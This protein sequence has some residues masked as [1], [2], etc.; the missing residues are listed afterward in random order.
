VDPT[1]MLSDS[2][3]ELLANRG[4]S[5]ETAQAQCSVLT[6]GVAAPV[7]SRAATVGDGVVR[8]APEALDAHLDAFAALARRGEVGFFVPASGAASRMF[9]TLRQFLSGTHPQA[10]AEEARILALARSPVVARNLWQKGIS[11]TDAR[12]VARLLVSDAPDGYGWASRPKA[13][14]PFHEDP[15]ESF[16]LRT[17]LVEQVAEASE[18]LRKGAHGVIHFTLPEDWPLPE[19]FNDACRML[20]LRH[21]GDVVAGASVQSP[22]TDTLSLDSEGALV[23][24]AQGCPVLRAGGHGALLPNLAMTPGRVVLVKNIDNIQPDSR[25]SWVV[26]WRRRLG[27]LAWALREAADRFLE[28][29]DANALRSLAEQFCIHLPA[30]DAQLREAVDRPLR[31]AGMVPNSGEPG[32][33]PFW[34]RST[35]GDERLEIVEQSEVAAG[36]R[37]IL[38]GSTHFNPVEIACC[39]RKPSGESYPLE[40]FVDGDR[41][42]LSDKPTPDGMVRVLEHPGLWNGS[43]SKWWTVFLELPPETFL[44]AKT[45]HDLAHPWRLSRQ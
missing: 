30:D 28:G 13:F 40:A 16:P 10:A 20:G 38:S 11:P 9:A 25:R 2:D 19:G 45:I 23:R 34:V 29:G 8:A 3:L 14:V 35:E 15:E 27:A 12:A 5:R 39:F 22:S 32:G 1:P 42:F 26:P 41:V 44:P 24:D 37:S 17:P 4:I 21:G 33:G 7:L 18:I 6:G 31:V 43:M 36:Q